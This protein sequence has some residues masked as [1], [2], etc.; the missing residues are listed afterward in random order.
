MLRK[1]DKFYKRS[2]FEKSFAAHCEQENLTLSVQNSKRLRKYYKNKK[3]VDL[4]A[5]LGYNEDLE[6]KEL[7]YR[8][9][10]SDPK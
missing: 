1:G 6:H 8:C 4:V 5:T 2:V 9:K 3:T 7:T 10:F